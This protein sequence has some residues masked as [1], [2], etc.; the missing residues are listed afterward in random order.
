MFVA[1]AIGSMAFYRALCFV[2]ELSHHTSRALPGFDLAYNLLAGYP[3]LMPSFVYV[4]V[5]QNH[6]KAS[7]YGTEKDPEYLPFAQSCWMTALFAIGGFLIP[8]MLFFRF[9]C[10]SPIGLVL[11]NFQRWLVIHASALTMN[12]KYRREANQ[13]LVG[14]IR[15]ESFLIF[16]GWAAYLSLTLAGIVSFRFLIVWLF[17]SSLLSL[18]NTARTLGSH[19][20]ESDGKPMDRM[21]QLQDS[22]DTPGAFWTELWAPVGLRYHAL[23][24]YF[25]GIPYHSLP[26]AYRRIVG[27]RSLKVDYERMSSSGLPASLSKLLKSGLRKQYTGGR[28]DHSGAADGVAP[29]SCRRKN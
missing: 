29:P 12:T 10:L 13:Q 16:L 23:H 20:Y 5:H 4:G 22:I 28:S 24:H 15:R 14:R 2:H 6:H 26:L 9:V 11:P 21:A 27:N 19:A 18:M 3:M 17:A 7:L 1:V 8:I 25:P